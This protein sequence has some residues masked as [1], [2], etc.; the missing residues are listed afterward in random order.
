MQCLKPEL[1]TSDHFSSRS[2]LENWSLFTEPIRNLLFIQGQ[3][4]PMSNNFFPPPIC[5]STPRGPDN[6]RPRAVAVS[7]RLSH[8][9]RCVI[10]A[11]NRYFDSK[12]FACNDD[13]IIVSNFHQLSSYTYLIDITETY[14]TWF[15][16]HCHLPR[17]NKIDTC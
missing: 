4:C 10:E 15:S 11:R 3:V 5:A 17:I 12:R 16:C 9:S 7:P 13:C 1:F 2:A 6:Y 14:I 8:W